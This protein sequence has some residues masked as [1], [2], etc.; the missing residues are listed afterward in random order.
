[1]ARIE[2]R[3]PVREGAHLRFALEPERLRFFDPQTTEA[4]GVVRESQGAARNGH[5]PAPEGGGGVGGR[6][7]RRRRG[8]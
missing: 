1:M 3:V 2:A 8:G 6:G 5:G 7:A 4:I